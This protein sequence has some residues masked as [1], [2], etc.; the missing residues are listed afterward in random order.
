MAGRRAGGRRQPGHA[1]RGAL[2]AEAAARAGAGLVKLSVPGGVGVVRPEIVQ[3]LV[4]A[5]QWAGAV[6]ADIDR[7][8]SLVIG[9]G[10]GREEETISCV[11]STI[12]EATVPVVIDGDALFAAAWDAVGAKPLFENRG[13]PTVLTPH[14]GE[15]A[16][17]DGITACR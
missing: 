14:D 2:C 7:F 11:R 15:F 8:G 17:S 12:D 16:L 10:L 5:E 6:L 3:Q 1:R 4:G 9:P 13:L